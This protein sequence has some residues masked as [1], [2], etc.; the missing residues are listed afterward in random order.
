MG[1]E[2][3]SWRRVF[4]RWVE[5][6]GP[7][8][9]IWALATASYQSRIAKRRIAVDLNPRPLA[10]RRDGIEVRAT[11]AD[12]SQFLRSGEVRCGF[13]LKFSRAPAFEGR[14]SRVH[15]RSIAC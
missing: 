13:Y 12:E 6:T 15:P 14:V 10:R 8:S 2:K 7:R 3:S 5:G 4:S 11:S 9:R 1:L